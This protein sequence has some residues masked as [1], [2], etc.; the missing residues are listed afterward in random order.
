ME[1]DIDWDTLW[2]SAVILFAMK[3]KDQHTKVG[4][5]IV[6]STNTLVQMGFNSP[7]RR[8]DDNIPSRFER[9]K[10]YEYME[11]AERNAIYN[12]AR[13]GVSPMG[14][15][16]YTNSLPCVPCARAIIQAGIN[17][18]IL[19]SPFEVDCIFD[20]YDHPVSRE[21]FFEAG[22]TVRISPAPIVKYLRGLRRGKRICG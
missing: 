3:S 20:D 14:C 9:P 15:R 8:V 16:L 12:C 5:V 7:P 19:W 10:K 11:H 6:D 21:M 2:L 17:E 1:H 18:V 13:L 4:A 22:V